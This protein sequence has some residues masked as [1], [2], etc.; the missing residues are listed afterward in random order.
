MIMVV[1]MFLFVLSVVYVIFNGSHFLNLL[2]VFEVMVVSVFVGL[3]CC[4]NFITCSFG[5][6]FSILFLTF[7]VCESVLGL[8][9]LVSVSRSSSVQYFKSFSFLGF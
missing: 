9:I 6:Y 7:A 2:L 1:F 4:F 3:F 5:L 8:S